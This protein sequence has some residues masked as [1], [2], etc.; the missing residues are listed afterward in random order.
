MKELLMNFELDLLITFL[1]AI[2]GIVAALYQV[3]SNI[4]TSSRVEWIKQLRVAVADFL[5]SVSLMNT[6][7]ENIRSEVANN[8]VDYSESEKLSFSRKLVKA[9]QADIDIL[10]SEIAKNNYLIKLHLNP[11]NKSHNDLIKAL[12]KY[13]EVAFSSEKWT[14]TDELIHE[15]NKCVDASRVVLNEA[16]KQTKRLRT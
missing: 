10:N 13:R 11:E 15:T 12:D 2:V 16:W 14:K 4:I 9:R 8:T 1:L 3:K 6:L 7:T 5:S